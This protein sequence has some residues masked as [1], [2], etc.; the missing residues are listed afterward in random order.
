MFIVIQRCL[1]RQASWDDSTSFREMDRLQRVDDLLQIGASVDVGDRVE[2]DD[3]RLVV[4][5]LVEDAWAIIC[6]SAGCP[7]GR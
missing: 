2:Q 3:V 6:Y 1:A 7:G 5:V 4:S